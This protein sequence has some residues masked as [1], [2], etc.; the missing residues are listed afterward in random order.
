MY[1]LYLVKQVLGFHRPSKLLCQTSWRQYH[2]SPIYMGA[3]RIRISQAINSAFSGLTAGPP[4]GRRASDC[5]AYS[6]LLAAKLI[7]RNGGQRIHQAKMRKVVFVGLRLFS[8]TNATPPPLPAPLPE[9]GSVRAIAQL[10][11]YPPPPCPPSC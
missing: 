6:T 10:S 8:Y 4:M 2:W 5:G 1:L 11:L 3:I 9:S 7:E